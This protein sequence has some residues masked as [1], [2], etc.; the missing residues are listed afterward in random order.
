M[1]R[2]AELLNMHNQGWMK[3]GG[4]G[5]EFINLLVDDRNEMLKFY[6]DQLMEIKT[7]NAELKQKIKMKGLN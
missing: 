7:I 4:T 1:D 3:I 2:L 5:E 6:G